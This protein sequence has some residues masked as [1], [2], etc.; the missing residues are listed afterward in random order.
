M[1]AILAHFP[2]GSAIAVPLATIAMLLASANASAARSD[3]AESA[4]E[5][6]LVAAADLPRPQ[7][8]V[9]ASTLPRFDNVD[10][11][12]QTA[13][14]DMRLMSAK[15]SGLGLALGMNNATGAQPGTIATLAPARSVDLGVH[16]RYT[17]DSNYR[18]DVTAY[19]RMPNADAISLIESRDPTYGA[20]VEMGFG[21]TSTRK[22]FVADRGFVGLQLEGGARLAVK[23]KNGGPM[24][25]YRNQ[26]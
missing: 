9:S 24:F 11:N 20:R 26:F 4:G 18:F 7:L 14:I 10:A 1:F 17:F 23:R 12:T 8:E 6:V 13:R 19:R 25:Y 21:S 3:R 15:Q 2:T 5:A 16:W 22:G